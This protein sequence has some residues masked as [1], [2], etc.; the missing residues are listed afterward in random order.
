MNKFKYI[1]Y[2]NLK[3]LKYFGI[4]IKS[5]CLLFSQVN[6]TN[7]NTQS[8]IYQHHKMINVWSH[9][10]VDPEHVMEC[11]KQDKRK[12]HCAPIHTKVFIVFLC[13]IIIISKMYVWLCVCRETSTMITLDTS[14][15]CI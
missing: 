6:A 5:M 4:I 7:V 14:V 15:C 1:F 12:V 10:C 13:C 8:K 11:K 3:T 2:L 9:E